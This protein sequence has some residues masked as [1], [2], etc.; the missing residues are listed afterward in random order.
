MIKKVSDF[1]LF[2]DRYLTNKWFHVTLQI[3]LI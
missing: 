3:K 1:Y 2:I